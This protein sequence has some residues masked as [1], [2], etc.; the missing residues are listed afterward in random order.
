MTL[1]GTGSRVATVI[2][3]LSCLMI[4]L[5]FIVPWYGVDFSFNSSFAFRVE[6][7]A[8]IGVEYRFIERMGDLMSLVTVVL[9]LS[10]VAS[11]IAAVLSYLRRAAG[12]IAGV[13]STGFLLSAGVVLCA[14]A[15][16]AFPLDSFSGL[17]NLNRTASVE[18]APMLGWWIAVTVPA[19]QV[20]QAAVLAYA[21]HYGARK[22]P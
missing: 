10:L 17:T 1:S 11:I 14:G 8:G 5:A 20:A 3:I 6:Y 18:T 19:V 2:G 4:G 21:D 13:Y 12:V 7:S 22:R 15:I 9:T 16:D